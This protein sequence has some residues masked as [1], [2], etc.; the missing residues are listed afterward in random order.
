LTIPKYEAGISSDN[1]ATGTIEVLRD[2]KIIVNRYSEVLRR[3][4][5]RYDYYTD[6]QSLSIPFSAP[7]KNELEIAVKDRGVKLRIITDLA[8]RESVSLCKNAMDV[9]ELRHLEGVKGNFGV[10]DTEYFAIADPSDPSSPQAVYS[11]M[12]LDVKQQHH[13][14][15]NLWTKSIPARQRI[16]EIEDGLETYFTDVIY[17]PEETIQ[18]YRS[19]VDSSKYELMLLLP[20]FSAFKRHQ[21]VGVLDSLIKLSE[22]SNMKVRILLPFTRA[23]QKQFENFL[24]IHRNINLHFMEDSVGSTKATILIGDRRNAFVMELRDD[25]KDNFRDAI[26]L[27]IHSNS[28]ASVQSYVSIYE[29]LWNLNELYQNIKYTNRKLESSYQQLK[30]KETRQEEL[31]SSL[32][33]TN[34]ELVNIGALLAKSNDE[35]VKKEM[36]LNKAN[37]E[38]KAVDKAKDEFISMVSHEL[39]TP[40][41]PI[42]SYAEMLLSPSI[43]GTELTERQKRAVLSIKRNA[44]KQQA[45]VEDILDVY[46]LD[47]GKVNLQ[48]KNINV[49]YFFDQILSDM[50]QYIVGKQIQLMTD[51]RVPSN[52]LINCDPNRIEQVISNMIKNSIDFVPEKDGQI[53]LKVEQEQH[54]VVGEKI[55]SNRSPTNELILTIQDNGI[56]IV[57]EKAKSLFTKFYQI[58]TSPTRKHTGS[59]LGLVICKGIVEA[60]GGRLWLDNTYTKGAVFKFTLPISNTS[61]GDN[62]QV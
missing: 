53:V 59:G 9:A 41:V 16:R 40:L 24:S 11:N 50:K 13:I 28:Q 47:M 8:N 4:Q 26:G 15:E 36:E 22:N 31:S 34:K 20:S 19:V 43:M 58:D 45:L 44:E 29:S 55:S 3:A 5:T 23:A 49:L 57:P 1:T 48:R 27:S 12:E 51:F 61:S 21:N 7:V 18:R 62:S 60:H 52:M 39:R 25:T 54:P 17:D 32:E 6:V 14:F 46:K 10:S 56:G 42:K 37:E 33:Q 30:L 2:E 38:L 35:L